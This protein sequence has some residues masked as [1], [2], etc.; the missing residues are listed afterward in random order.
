MGTRQIVAVTYLLT[1]V[2]VL[3]VVY[4]LAPSLNCPKY[5][6]LIKLCL[7]VCSTDL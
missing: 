7:G 6:E 3:N 5:D 1:V 2:P 4:T